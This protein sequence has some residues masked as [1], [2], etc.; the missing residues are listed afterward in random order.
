M[1]LFLFGA[2]RAF[3]EDQGSPADPSAISI[4]GATDS[5]DI[6]FSDAGTYEAGCTCI[7]CCIDKLRKNI[8]SAGTGAGKITIRLKAR[9]ERG[10]DGAISVR[11]DVEPPILN[12]PA[13]LKS[14]TRDAVTRDV[15]VLVSR[16]RAW[17]HPLTPEEIKAMSAA[18]V[19]FP[20]A[21]LAGSSSSP[22]TVTL[23]VRSPPISVRIVADAAPFEHLDSIKVGKR[24]R[25]EVAY[26]ADPG[27]DTVAVIVETTSG[28]KLE[29]SAKRTIDASTYRTEPI[30]LRGDG[31][32]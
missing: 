9:L 7:V 13:T 6:P 31:G 22:L 15:S 4:C 1:A 20:V 21:D 3:A 8:D 24:F 30:E 12:L 16:V 29:I 25:V 27:A 32:Q 19:T 10:A 23:C 2:L 17:S 11:M 18:P 28:S 5:V 26:S 14:A